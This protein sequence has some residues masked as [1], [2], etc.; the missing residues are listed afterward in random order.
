MPPVYYHDGKFPPDQLDWQ[1]LIPLIGPA[2]A[3][4]ARYDGVLGT[5]PN[6]QLLLSP[7]TT[8]EAVLSSKIEGTQATM[9]EVLEFEAGDGPS[10]E[11]EP[12]KV[13]DIQEILNYRNALH[14]ARQQLDTLPL[15]TRLIRDTHRILLTGVRGRDKDPGNFRTLQNWIG[16]HGCAEKEAR[17]VTISP[18]KLPDGMSRWEKY[19]HGSD[20][21][22]P[23]VQLAIVHA[24][25][26][27]LHPFWD[28]NGR[29]GRM[30]IPLFLFERKLLA[31]PSFYLSEQLEA[32]R[33]IYYD[34]L[35]AVSKDGDWTGWCVFFLQA[36]IT[37]AKSNTRKAKAILDLYESKK[38]W[39]IERTHSQHAIPALD[40]V[41]SRPIFRAN[42]FVHQPAIP[43][44]SAR[45]ILNELKKG[46]DA[47]LREMRPSSGRRPALMA[48]P[49]LMNVAEGR[50]A[51]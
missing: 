4:L 43:E 40:F 47:I 6:A 24:E 20:E 8:H 46:E 32:D 13:G 25:F 36:F 16:N 9:G 34:K 35:L 41:F 22:D 14:H 27:S 7:L 18:E 17:F 42:D 5:L 45:R 10:E 12:Q 23:I 49:E 21:M 50:D 37:Q 48:F 28:G 26:E 33:E 39:I 38:Q 1:K 19:I 3:A 11:E 30:L 15:S 2:N 31:S 29:I 44:P 51:F